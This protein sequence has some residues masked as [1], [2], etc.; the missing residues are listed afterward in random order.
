MPLI[1]NFKKKL[2]CTLCLLCCCM[3]TCVRVH[4][5]HLTMHPNILPFALS[6]TVIIEL[7]KTLRNI[8]LNLIPVKQCRH[9]TQVAIQRY[10]HSYLLD[11]FSLLADLG[12]LFL[13]CIPSFFMVNGR[14][15]YRNICRCLRIPITLSFYYNSG[16]I[17]GYVIAET[18]CIKIV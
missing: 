6:G 14:F 2:F 18:T 13:V 16:I 17:H 5:N 11:V 12:F 8:L 10:L 9:S 7:F 1:F 4:S 15:T 3:L